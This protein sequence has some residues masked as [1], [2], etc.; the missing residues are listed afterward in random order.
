MTNENVVDAHAAA[1]DYDI[2][3]LKEQS[4]AWLAV[5]DILNVVAPG[6]QAKGGRG[7]DCA[8]N[9]IQELAAP[10]A[11]TDLSKRLRA[12]AV[13][14]FGPEDFVLLTQAADEIERYYGGMMAW[15]KT[16]EKK[17]KDWND[18]RMARINDR[19]AER[20]AAPV[21]HDQA[22]SVP[23]RVAMLEKAL[24]FYA[25]GEHFHLHDADAW[26]TVSGEPANFYED[27]SN[28]ATVEDGSVAKMALAGT[29]VADD[30]AA[31]PLPPAATPAPELGWISVDE[32]LPGDDCMVL[33]AAKRFMLGDP[34][35]QMV[36]FRRGTGEFDALHVTHWQSLPPPPAAIQAQGSDAA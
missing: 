5:V 35:I 16:A 32:R 34:I 36:W 21:A 20:A 15:K 24:K 13:T 33:V 9:A 12:K 14:P 22:Q 23:D 25:D 4:E 31:A 8:V 18:E 30:D 7:I 28:T 17:D 29:P 19:C 27:E 3:S 26:D 6:W 11:P 1:T 2:G 10:V